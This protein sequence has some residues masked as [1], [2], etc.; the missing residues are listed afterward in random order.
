MTCERPENSEVIWMKKAQIQLLQYVKWVK[1]LEKKMRTDGIKTAF[2]PSQGAGKST[3]YDMLKI[4][5]QGGSQGETDIHI[6]IPIHI[7]IHIHT[8]TYTYSISFETGSC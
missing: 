3:E 8:H 7:D 4:I 1:K 6:L 5:L 2:I